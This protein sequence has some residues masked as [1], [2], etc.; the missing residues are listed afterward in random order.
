M[1]ADCICVMQGGKVVEKGTHAE[2]LALNGVYTNL[3]QAQAVR[4]GWH[5]V[6]RTCCA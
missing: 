3:V 1:L 4:C 6:N 5:Y 2:L